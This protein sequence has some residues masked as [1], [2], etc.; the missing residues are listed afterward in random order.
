MK[1]GKRKKKGKKQS[2]ADQTIASKRLRQISEKETQR[3]AQKA[4]MTKLKFHR[5]TKLKQAIFRIGVWTMQPTE[6]EVL[7]FLAVRFDG[8]GLKE[9]GR[10]FKECCAKQDAECAADLGIEQRYLEGLRSVIEKFVAAI[11]S[12]NRA[13]SASPDLSPTTAIIKTNLGVSET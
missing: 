9:L 2:P 4:Q 5:Y 10:W 3:I 13:K 1:H 7:Q 6:I 12:S 11:E 8:D